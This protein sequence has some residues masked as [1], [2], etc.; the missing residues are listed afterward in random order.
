MNNFSP[1]KPL[2]STK[3]IHHKTYLIPHPNAQKPD[4]EAMM[5]VNLKEFLN[6]IETCQKE[7]N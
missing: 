4:A 6:N 5:S 7:K 3:P 2:S 1:Q